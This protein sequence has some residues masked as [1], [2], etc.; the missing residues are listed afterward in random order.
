MAASSPALGAVEYMVDYRFRDPELLAR[1]LRHG[2]AEA[3]GREGSYE[4]LEFLGDAVLGLAV[5]QLLYDRF[6]DHD[7]GALTRMRALLTRS[8]TLAAKAAEIGLEHSVEAGR[9][10]LVGVT[11]PR[12]ALLEDVLEAVIGAIYLDGG[13]EPAF[14]FIE[15]LFGDDLEEL[16]ESALIRAD[17]KTALQEAA[18]ARALPLPEYRELGSSGPDHRRRWTVEVVWDG[19]VIATGEGLSKRAA[20]KEAARIALELLGITTTP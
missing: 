1:A 17:P 13:P 2:S 5:G 3:A 20:Q 7:Q 15:R 8:S 16:D 12:R 9:S 18:Q 4:R 14:A 11:A 19:E 10:E 6:P